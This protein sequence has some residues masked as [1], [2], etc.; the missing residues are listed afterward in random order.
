M[1]KQTG[2]KLVVATMI[3]MFFTII[4]LLI[5]PTIIT[6]TTEPLSDEAHN[7]NLGEDAYSFFDTLIEQWAQAF[8]TILLLGEIV[9]MIIGG[10]YAAY[11]E[12]KPPYQGGYPQYEQ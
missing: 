9:F 7:R 3:L 8:F 4:M 6:E 11:G 2:M 10:Y 1:Y 12:E 5:S